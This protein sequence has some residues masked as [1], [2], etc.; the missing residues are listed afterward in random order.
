MKIEVNWDLCESN[1]VC[2]DIV[3]SVFDINDDDELVV[4]QD[5]ITPDLRGDLEEAVRLCPRQALTLVT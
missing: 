1:G 4:T 3:P 5:A 2:V